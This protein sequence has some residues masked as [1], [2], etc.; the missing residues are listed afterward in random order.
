MFTIPKRSPDLNVCDY[1]LWATANRSMRRQE[2]QFRASKRETRQE[3]LTRLHKTATCLS[4]RCIDQAI[5]DIRR[6]C[7]RLHAARSGLFEEGGRPCRR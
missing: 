2:K 7:Q 1:R 4:K 5:G 6:R 3:F